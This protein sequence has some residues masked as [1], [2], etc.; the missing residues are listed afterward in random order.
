MEQASTPLFFQLSAVFTAIAVAGMLMNAKKYK[1][2]LLSA[3]LFSLLSIVLGLFLARFIFCTNPEQFQ[4]LFY[5]ELG[6]YL[7]PQVFWQPVGS[8]FHIGGFLLGIVLAAILTRLITK[9]S[10]LSL[11]DSIALPAL[12]LFAAIRFI[13]P[14]SNAPDQ[15]MKGFSDVLE[16]T[17]FCFTPLFYKIEGMD[18]D[19]GETIIQWKLAVHLVEA[20][21]AVIILF[22]LHRRRFAPGILAMYTAVLFSTSQLLPESLRQ[23]GHL[24]ISIFL[25]VTYLSLG[26]LYVLT[27]FFVLFRAWR[28]GVAIKRLAVET[29]L[30]IICMG[31]FVVFEF[32]LDGKVTLFSED[33]DNSLKKTLIHGFMG[34]VLAGMAFITC[35][36]IHKENK[37]CL[38]E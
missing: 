17:D 18:W 29:L 2:S 20:I 37:A 34:I 10:F 11:M 38:A 8:G 15:T 30:V 1:V 31:L 21:L 9:A 19:T 16:N 36:R 33:V 24:C 32:A 5:D 28:R 6:E 35:Q 26:I 4:F 27:H 13:E 12:F 7:G 23:D 25:R 14:L 22:A 3:G